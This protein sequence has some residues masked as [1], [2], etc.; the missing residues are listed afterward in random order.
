MKR[1]VIL[2]ILGILILIVVTFGL[3][4]AFMRPKEENENETQISIK[5]CAKIVFDE[6]KIP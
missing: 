5:A 4:Y 3:T 6:K 2:T 1:Y